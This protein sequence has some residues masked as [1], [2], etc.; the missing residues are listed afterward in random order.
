[1][2]M[3]QT[4]VFKKPYTARCIALKDPQGNTV[5]TLKQA[6][7]FANY[8]TNSYWRPPTQGCAASQSN[9]HDHAPVDMQPIAAAELK[10]ILAL[11][12]NSKAPGPDNIP[13]EAYEWLDDDNRPLLQQLINSILHNRQLPTEWHLANGVEIYKGKG[14]TTDPEMYR[15]ISLLSTAYNILARDQTSSI[16]RS[17]IEINAVRIQQERIMLAAIP[18][19]QKATRQSR[20]NRQRIVPI[21]P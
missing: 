18:H 5:N 15:P 12:K 20:A 1:M 6:D 9:V 11:G 10:H 21:F 7:T 13:T 17:Q 3:G 19:C 4:T 2:E 14:S 8:L 16:T